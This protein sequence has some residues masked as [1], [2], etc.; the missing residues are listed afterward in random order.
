M[1]I[2]S[3]NFTLFPADLISLRFFGLKIKTHLSASHAYLC[4]WTAQARINVLRARDEQR[5]CLSIQQ[6]GH[7]QLDHLAHELQPRLN[8]DG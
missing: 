5:C 6:T 3:M 8:A 4:S 2:R 1:L 7:A